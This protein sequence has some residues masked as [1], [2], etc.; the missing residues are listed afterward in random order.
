M[1]SLGSYKYIRKKT[2]S[3]FHIYMSIKP[4]YSQRLISR[5]LFE[6]YIKII[7]SENYLSNEFSK[8]FVQQRY[9]KA[10]EFGVKFEIIE[11]PFLSQFDIIDVNTYF[12]EAITFEN[13]IKNYYDN[14]KYKI[15]I[16]GK[17]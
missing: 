17:F 7:Y 13:V 15:K 1:I 2:T 3:K 4:D 12:N 16:S 8:I 11:T 14:R 6:N 10:L 9:G 5:Q